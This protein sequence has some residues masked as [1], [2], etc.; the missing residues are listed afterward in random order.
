[1]LFQLFMETAS[2]ISQHLNIHKRRLIIIGL[3]YALVNYMKIHQQILSQKYAVDVIS[4]ESIIY[5]YQ[6]RSFVSL[7]GDLLS[8]AKLLLKLKPCYVIS[9]GP[10]V[11][12]LVSLFSRLFSYQ[13][14]HWFTGQAWALA[15]PPWLH[16]SYL[17]DLIICINS[18]YL[19]SDSCS[20]VDFVLK[21]MPFLRDLAISAPR[22]GSISYV[23]MSLYKIG[24]HRVNRKDGPTLGRV[25]RLG[26]LGRI[27]LDKGLDTINKL[28]NDVCSLPCVSIRVSGP[29]DSSLG[30]SADS[31]AR[32]KISSILL[33][34]ESNPR[35]ILE[36]GF[37]ERQAFF[38][39]IDVLV[40]P[41]KREGFGSVVI[42]ANAC[43]IPVICS[44]IYGLSDSVQHGSNGY[45]ASSYSDYVDAIKLVADPFVY[46]GLAKSAFYRSLRYSH[47]NMRDALTSLYST[48]LPL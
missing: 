40:L 38:S 14:I 1:M 42:E 35:V 48:F 9:V 20:Q 31:I 2:Q 30:G 19:L 16:P 36:I 23:P 13:H 37:I 22:H 43:G 47:L 15:N 3:D 6:R 39:E 21:R 45:V 27:C 32:A 5:G 41:S 17:V 11:G 26:F 28:A 10:K 33:D 8:L 46:C 34:L 24:L 44:N 4:I 29:L 12:L 25:I 7:P 18:K